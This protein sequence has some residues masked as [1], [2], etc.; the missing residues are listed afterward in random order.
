MLDSDCRPT[1]FGEVD[2]LHER[3]GLA[4]GEGRANDA[5]LRMSFRGYGFSL[6]RGGFDA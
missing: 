4:R 1:D 6:K 3:A 5:R 2:E